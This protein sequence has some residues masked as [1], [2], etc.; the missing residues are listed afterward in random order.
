MTRSKLTIASTVFGALAG[1][2]L[3]G[4]ITAAPAMAEVQVVL[5]QA[6]ILRLPPKVGTIIIGNPAIADITIQRSGIAIVTGKTYGTTNMIILGNAG[7]MISE[8]QVIVRPPDEAIVTVQRG[9]DRE[10]LACTPNCEKTV[11]VG[12][13]AA[14]FDFIAGQATTRS[15]LATPQKAGTQ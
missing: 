13:A 9:M 5:D 8:E 15:G 2:A 3:A 10:S 7:E 12:D 14:N 11:M 4:V 1:V 6:K